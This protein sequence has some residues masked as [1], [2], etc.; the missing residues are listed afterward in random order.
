M[1]FSLLLQDFNS[2]NDSVVLGHFW[3]HIPCLYTYYNISFHVLRNLT[4]TGHNNQPCWVTRYISKAWWFQICF[5]FHST[6]TPFHTIKKRNSTCFNIEIKRRSCFASPN[7][8]FFEWRMLR[9]WQKRLQTCYWRDILFNPQ[10]SLDLS[11]DTSNE[12]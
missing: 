6:T 5:R 3:K 9:N 12:S 11:C 8:I 7:P 1:S 10:I 2:V 4:S